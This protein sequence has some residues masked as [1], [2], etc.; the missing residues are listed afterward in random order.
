MFTNGINN[1]LVD[2]DQPRPFPWVVSP[3]E[4]MLQELLPLYQELWDC[5]TSQWGPQSRRVM[6]FG[7]LNG[8][9]PHGVYLP[10]ITKEQIIVRTII[11]HGMN[12]RLTTRLEKIY[13]D[14]QNRP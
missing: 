3:D 4:N 12:S 14:S 2:R 13:S 8:L 10:G 7:H 1:E 11:M 9:S 5:Y 6:V